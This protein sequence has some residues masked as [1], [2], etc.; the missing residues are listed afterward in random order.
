MR[1]RAAQIGAGIRAED[2]VKNAIAF[3]CRTG[4]LS[5]AD[6]PATRLE[7]ADATR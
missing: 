4:L 5:G 1:H 6:V 7:I 2:G 3:L